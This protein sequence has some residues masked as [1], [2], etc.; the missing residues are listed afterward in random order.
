MTLEV[1]DLSRHPRFTP[2]LVDAFFAEWPDWCNRVGRGAVER[3]FEGAAPLPVILV[4]FRGDALAGTIAL[5]PWFAEAPMPRSP[6]VRQ[7]LVLPPYRGRGVDRTL[8]AAI[9]DRARSLGF[10]HLHA[11]TNRIE[12]LLA[13]RGWE[14]FD[15]VEVDGEK[16]AWLRLSIGDQ[17]PFMM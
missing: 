10:A 2:R 3:I 8:I 7:L 1:D 15:R 14:V 16:F 11:A 9:T 4:A 12:R 6:W 5:R 13:R 17:S